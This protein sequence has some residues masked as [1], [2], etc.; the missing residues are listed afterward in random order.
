MDILLSSELKKL[1]ENCVSGLDKQQLAPDDIFDV[2]ETLAARP[3]VNKRIVGHSFLNR[4]I[5]CFTLGQGPIHVLMWTQ[6][7]GDESTATAAVLD[8]IQILSEGESESESAG[9]NEISLH[10]VPMLNPDGAIAGTRENAQGI[11]I[12]RDALAL[13]TP[14]G[15]ILNTLVNEINPDFAFNLHDQDDYFRCGDT[16]KSATLAFLA[17][18]FNADKSVDL[19]RQT[20][21][22]LI[23]LMHKHASPMLKQGI[24]RYDDEFSAR[25]F[26]DQIA[27]KGISTVLIESGHYADDPTRQVARTLNVSVLLHALNHICTGAAWT[28]SKELEAL[29]KQYWLIPENRENKVCD[30]L[31]Q[32]IGF[33]G[34]PYKA[35][36]AIRKKSRFSAN[37]FIDDIGDLSEQYGLRTID[38]S[39][40]TFDPGRSYLLSEKLIL[41]NERYL[42][43]LQQGFSHFVGDACL[44]I[45]NSEYDVIENPKYWHDDHKMMR[46]ITPAGFLCQNGERKF[47][48]MA[49][50]VFPL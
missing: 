32:K 9:N 25:S 4:P 1:R 42:E 27:K 3:G 11:D 12:N 36:I 17:P 13:Q 30:I 40:Y 38:A 50:H 35:D 15:I 8:I 39:S 6:M 21:M 18:A 29:E 41:N 33:T 37:L 28:D 43:I 16:G 5:H 26:G 20:A 45:N 23:A 49:G 47:A 7:H 2:M 14:E 31:I 44:I 10:I 46:G 48:I 22:G 34:T 24:A 19:A